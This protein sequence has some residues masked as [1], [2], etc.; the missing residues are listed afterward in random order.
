M[1]DQTLIVSDNRV[2]SSGY[3][4]GRAL[5]TTPN[6]ETLEMQDCH[7]HDRGGRPVAYSLRCMN[8]H[9]YINTHTH[10]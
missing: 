7:L 10:R 1:I 6:L 3:A 4:F 9:S 2:K 5:H 8:T